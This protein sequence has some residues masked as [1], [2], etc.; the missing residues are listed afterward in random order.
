MQGIFD[1]LLVTVALGIASAWRFRPIAGA[2]RSL[3]LRQFK[4]SAFGWMFAMLGAY[5]LGAVIFSA[6]VL[7]P[8]QE[9]IGKELGSATPGSGSRSP[10]SC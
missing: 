1:G 6:L 10:P 5:Y 9:D 3:G 8:E 4:L 2:L 7:Q